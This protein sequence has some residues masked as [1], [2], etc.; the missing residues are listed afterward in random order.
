M[1]FMFS[2]PT[3]ISLF[4]VGVFILLVVAGA[5]G[6]VIFRAVRGELN[7]D[8]EGQAAQAYAEKAR[9]RQ[10]QRSK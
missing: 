6:V 4:F 8:F 2:S 7:V 5:I 3:M 10:S 1:G 9:Q